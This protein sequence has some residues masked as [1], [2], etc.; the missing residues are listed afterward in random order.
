MQPPFFVDIIQGASDKEPL[1]KLDSL[2][3]DHKGPE[4]WI[5]IKQVEVIDQ[6][7]RIQLL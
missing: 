3:E 2:N 5:R 4:Y 7:I 6:L 1:V